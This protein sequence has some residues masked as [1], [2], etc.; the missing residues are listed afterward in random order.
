MP[1]LSR[2][3]DEL[4]ARRELRA[5]RAAVAWLNALGYPAIVP[6]ELIRPLRGAG[7]VVWPGQRRAA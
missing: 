7:L 1:T 6:P 5:W 4:A 3:L 2:P